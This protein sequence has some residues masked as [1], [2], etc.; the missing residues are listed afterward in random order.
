MSA[1][2]QESNGGVSTTVNEKA[3]GVYSYAQRSLDRV[4]LPEN[5]QKAYDITADFARE[6]PV[7]FVSPPILHIP[8]PHN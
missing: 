2:K 7:V 3:S 4:V 5:R 6:R 1:Y 8:Q